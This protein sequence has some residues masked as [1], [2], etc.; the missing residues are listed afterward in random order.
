MK[1]TC[2]KTGKDVTSDVIVNIEKSLIEAGHKLFKVEID[3]NGNQI[4]IPITHDEHEV[5]PVIKKI[6]SL[7][8]NK[9]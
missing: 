9:K 6:F 5:A 1:V 3:E 8:K 2:K 7:G 4:K